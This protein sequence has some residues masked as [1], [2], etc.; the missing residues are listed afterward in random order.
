MFHN[1]FINFF[2]FAGEYLFVM[3]LP[4]NQTASAH[5]SVMNWNYITSFPR[6]HRLAKYHSQFSTKL[7]I[8]Q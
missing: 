8:K 4:I 5:A 1:L 3:N 6:T 2:S 7:A